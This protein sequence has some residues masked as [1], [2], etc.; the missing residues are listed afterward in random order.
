MRLPPWIMCAGKEIEALLCQFLYAR[1]SLSRPGWFIHAGN[2]LASVGSLT[3][4][5]Q[6]PSLK[7]EREK[8]IRA[9][10]FQSFSLQK[11]RTW[12]GKSSHSS[13]LTAGNLSKHR[14]HFQH[15]PKHCTEL[16]CSTHC[17]VVLSSRDFTD[18]QVLKNSLWLENVRT[19]V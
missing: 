15:S 10:N 11:S 9:R 7:K 1:A 5:P 17:L 13:G 16:G 12:K 19:L 6:N 14:F 18:K 4:T 2:K 3:V 8:K